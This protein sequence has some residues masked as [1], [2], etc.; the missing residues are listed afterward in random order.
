VRVKSLPREVLEVASGRIRISAEALE[1]ARKLAR[2]WY[3]YALQADF[4]SWAQGLGETAVRG[5]ALSW[6]HHAAAL[7]WSAFA[8]TNFIATDLTNQRL[9]SAAPSTDEPR[10]AKPTFFWMAVACYQPRWNTTKA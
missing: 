5:Y 1:A 2:G 9:T 3:V 10:V 7:L 4:R 8:V 6:R